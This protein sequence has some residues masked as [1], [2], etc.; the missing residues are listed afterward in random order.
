M[1]VMLLKRSSGRLYFDVEGFGRALYELRITNEIQ[2][3][4]LAQVC[5][6][7]LVKE[8]RNII[9]LF[10]LLTSAQVT[11]FRLR[12]D[13]AR[14]VSTLSSSVKVFFVFSVPL[15]T[16]CEIMIKPNRHIPYLTARLKDNVHVFF[17]KHAVPNGTKKI[18][19]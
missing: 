3:S 5:M 2:F 7:A 1:F 10:C 19:N 17:Y 9:S 12:R 18:T 14:Y 13:V 4:L 11:N 16:Q 6:P 15:G 8:K